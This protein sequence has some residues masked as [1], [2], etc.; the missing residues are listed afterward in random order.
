[1][2]E[3][4]VVN[5]LVA[6]MRRGLLDRKTFLAEAAALGMSMATARQALAAAT[7]SRRA[8]APV[9]GGNLLYGFQQPFSS[10]DPTIGGLQIEEILNMSCMDYLMW[11]RPG[12]PRLYPGLATSM[13]V[14]ADAKSYTFHLRKD[15]V[16]HDGTP[17]NAQALQFNNDRNAKAGK[18]AGNSALGASYS[19]TEVI[20]DYTAKMVFSQPYSSYLITMSTAFAGPESPTAIKKY[21][22]Q[23]PFHI[24]ATGPFM[25]KD[26]VVGDHVT[27]VRNPRYHWGPS[28]FKHQGPAYLDSITFRAIPS[29]IARVVALQ[30]NQVHLIDNV[31]AQ[32]FDLLKNNTQYKTR[33]QPGPGTPWV[34][35]L[36][37]T[38]PPTNELAVRQAI[39]YATNQQQISELVFNGISPAVHNLL[40][41]GTQG[42]SAKTALYTYNPAKA[43]QLLDAA[44]WKMGSNGIR[45]K[46]GKQLQLSS[47][48]IAN[49]GM[50]GMA[51]VLQ[52]QLKAVGINMVIQS[53]EAAAAFADYAAKKA[54]MSWEFYN[55]PDPA[56][57]IG[58]FYS[59]QALKTAG[60]AGNYLNPKVTAL[61]NEGESVTDPVKRAAVYQQIDQQI[62]RD[63]A[64]LPL[65]NRAVVLASN[66][67]VALEDVFFTIQGDPYFYDVSMHQ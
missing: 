23:Y 30:S 40:T 15:V 4:A 32:N 14:S 58:N 20:D 9:R 1:M 47:I 18:G 3:D 44:G 22:T 21:G 25:L 24:T 53:L 26:L 11:Q 46:N 50:D 57:A 13:Q 35:A 17:F 62:L 37:M 65:V 31:P 38:L 33:V 29:D 39:E 16:F 63:A 59:P 34:I 28:F 41:P 56:E 64:S 8:S 60:N 36:H 66:T 12:D 6:R 55:D 2:A 27:Y 48:I 49:F 67:K 19:H 61:F 42:Y 52:Q 5:Q 7:S 54:N 43:N 10:I 51:T 45:Q